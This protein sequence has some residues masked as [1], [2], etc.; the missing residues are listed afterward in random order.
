MIIETLKIILRAEIEQYTKKIDEAKK[1]TDELGDKAEQTAERGKKAVEEA[2]HKAEDMRRTIEEFDRTG[3]TSKVDRVI[4]NAQKMREAF[5]IGRDESGGVNK[6]VN[7]LS[8]AAGK[9]KSVTS[10]LGD[11][12]RAQKLVNATTLMHVTALT[13]VLAAAAA[14]LKK[15]ADIAAE[16]AALGD[17]I[18]KTSQKLNMSY[19]SYQRW[20]Y[21]MHLCGSS[22]EE[23]KEGQNQ[24]LTQM[25]AAYN[26][27][28]T[29]AGYFQTLG[30][31]VQD[32]NGQLRSSAQVFADVITQLQRMENQTQRA[33]IAQKLFGEN[34]SKL[35]PLLNMTASQMQNVT[36]TA[37]TL[38]IA[39]NDHTVQLS[40]KYTDAVYTLKQAWQACK[41]TLAEAVLPTLI[42]VAKWLATGTVY[43]RAFINAMNG[44]AGHRGSS[45]SFD[46]TASGIKSVGTAASGASGQVAAL[47]RQL[48]GFDEMNVIQKDSSSTAAA[49]VPSIDFSGLESLVTPVESLFSDEELDRI[50]QIRDKIE[51]ITTTF[52]GTILVLDGLNK[53]F[54]GLITGNFP[55]V[56]KGFKEFCEGLGFDLDKLPEY[57]RGA[58]NKVSEWFRREVKPIFTHAWWKSHLWNPIA[59]WWNGLSFVQGLR[60]KK[61]KVDEWWNEH[62]APVFTRQ[63][64]DQKIK[65][66]RDWWNGLAPV[67]K[68][69]DIQN[70][71]KDWWKGV[72][73]V[74]TKDYW[75]EKFKP[76]HDAYEEHIGK[77][78]TKKYW[79]D[80]WAEVVEDTRQGINGV[81]E[82]IET[83]L[84]NALTKL[85]KF[86][87]KLPDWMGGHT[88]GFNFKPI[89]IPRLA[90]GGIVTQSTLANIGENGAEAVL[91]LQNNTGWMD[92]LA[93]RLASRLGGGSVVLKVD[94]RELGR[95]SYR[96]I[97][98]IARETGKCPIVVG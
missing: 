25:N 7:A 76:V 35:A 71:A 31:R 56:K 63:F 1:K 59:D 40:A 85:N 26:G 49:S 62:I 54:F 69:R 96:G 33:A 14:V 89:R 15:I 24:L 60:E 48:M 57:A 51:E 46:S 97:N 88:F 22:A 30:V 50:A 83:G 90:T 87:I 86:S 27:D 13:A 92:I 66:A 47:K 36:R 64:W 9:S 3:L 5:K 75:K 37:Q 32:S 65:I 78:F 91:P 10:A 12:V 20:D 70:D 44:A 95:A 41:N 42:Q 74:F 38:G 29:A 43:V 67:K 84:N 34:A 98:Q 93:D 52:R 11:T 19:A 28:K 2:T 72:K 16:T 58:W 21:I 73:Q 61:K 55:L 81:L 82:K 80:K 79:Q 6:Q 17:Q 45:Y 77:Y 53:M 23:L 68:L 94:G 8:A 39:M 18:D 4:Q